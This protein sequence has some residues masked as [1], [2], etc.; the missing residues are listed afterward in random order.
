MHAG[1]MLTK[2]KLSFLLSLLLLFFLWK[3][4]QGEAMRYSTLYVV[5]S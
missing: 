5:A 3:E 1:A 4:A 2:A